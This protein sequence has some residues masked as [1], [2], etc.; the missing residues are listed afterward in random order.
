MGGEEKAENPPA[1]SAATADETPEPAPE[2]VTPTEGPSASAGKSPG[3]ADATDELTD[4]A[5]N[6]FEPEGAEES[7]ASTDERAG[8]AATGRSF[9][10]LTGSRDRQRRKNG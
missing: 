4:A 6:L 1:E 7:G 5:D 10:K 9:G 3:A 2:S 8:D